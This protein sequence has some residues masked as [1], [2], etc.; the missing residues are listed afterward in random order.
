[1]SNP[2]NAPQL[3][4]GWVI[5]LPNKIQTQ[6][7]LVLASSITAKQPTNNSDVMLCDH[8]DHNDYLVGTTRQTKKPPNS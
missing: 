7:L 1:M 8:F 4:P 5:P 6:F 3:S 2:K